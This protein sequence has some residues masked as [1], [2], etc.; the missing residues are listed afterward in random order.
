MR[1]IDICGPLIMVMGYVYIS[2]LEFSPIEFSS[3][4]LVLLS[5][6][7]SLASLNSI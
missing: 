1:F 3:L 7:T 5:L 6:Y 2:Y 4:V